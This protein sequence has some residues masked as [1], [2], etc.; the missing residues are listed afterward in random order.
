MHSRRRVRQSGFTLLEVLVAFVVATIGIVAIVQA[1]SGGLRGLARLDSLG[2]GALVA[3]SRLAEVGAIYPVSTGQ[4]EG[5]D[6]EGKYNWVISIT[7]YEDPDQRLVPA[8]DAPSLFMVTVDVSWYQGVRPRSFRLA[9]LRTG[10]A[11]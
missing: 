6:G 11:I 1:F 5:T 4:F 9:T 10:A 2:V 7:P 8:P 3:E